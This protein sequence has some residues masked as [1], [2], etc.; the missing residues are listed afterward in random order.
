[1]RTWEPI[2]PFRAKSRTT[3]VFNALSTDGPTVGKQDNAWVISLIN[4]DHNKKP[5]KGIS[6][7]YNSN[8]GEVGGKVEWSKCEG[9]DIKLRKY[10]LR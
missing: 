5:I 4:I 10:P 7:E 8:L 1:M 9:E 3:I 2:S 6:Y